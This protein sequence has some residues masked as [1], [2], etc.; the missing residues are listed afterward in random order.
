[1][2]GLYLVVILVSMPVL[3]F[4]QEQHQHQSDQAE[5]AKLTTDLKAVVSAMEGPGLPVEALPSRSAM[6]PLAPALQRLDVTLHP[7][8]RVAL[9]ATSKTE[10]RGEVPTFAGLLV[11]SVPRD[12]N[13]RV[14]A[15]GALWLDVLEGDKVLERRKLDRRIQCGHVHKS[16]GFALT[17]G[18][19]YWL[20]LSGSKVQE[21]R[22]LLSS[23]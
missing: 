3:A 4:G 5:C 15:D 21:V 6:E 7:A 8:D 10:K 18:V 22:L 11:F 23:E 2:R 20:Q 12:G 9:T 13:Y 17:A 16:L 19:M 1:M 14:S